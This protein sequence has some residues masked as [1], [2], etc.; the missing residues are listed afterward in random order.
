MI[1]NGY[2]K[3]EILEDGTVISTCSNRGPRFIL[4]QCKIKGGY[5]Q[6]CLTS[7]DKTKRKQMLVHRLVAQAFIPNP[8]NL[9][10][11]DHKDKNRSNNHKDNLQWSSV[12]SNRDSRDMTKLTRR[13]RNIITGKEY[14]SLRQ[15]A[16]ENKVKRTHIDYCLLHNK[17]GWEYIR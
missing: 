3:Y 4:K 12:K 16:K 17:H 1:I 15:A 5:V 14:N 10:E 13:C 8:L 7:S 9:P 11:V 2:E 6:V